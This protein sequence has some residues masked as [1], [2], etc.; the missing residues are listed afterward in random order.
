ML[1]SKEQ[2]TSPKAASEVPETTS[3]E[4]KEGSA[5]MD[6]EGQRKLLLEELQS[7]DANGDNILY[8]F[9]RIKEENNKDPE[10]VMGEDKEEFIRLISELRDKELREGIMR[11]ELVKKFDL[12]ITQETKDA[13]KAGVII[14]LEHVQAPAA[15]EDAIKIAE[16]Y[17]VDIKNED[18]QKAAENMAEETEDDGIRK[19]VTADFLS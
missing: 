19:K 3:E 18:I 4:G 17:E 15:A 12:P 10:E 14:N 5:S 6:Y 1:K 11:E 8:R 13:A 2:V 7:E 9:R 16:F